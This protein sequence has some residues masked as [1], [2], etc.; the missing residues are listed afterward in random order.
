MTTGRGP[1][2]LI[3]GGLLDTGPGRLVEHSEQGCRLLARVLSRTAQGSDAGRRLDATN[4]LKQ[5]AG[6]RQADAFGLGDG[7]EVVLKLRGQENGIL[8]AVLEGLKFGLL[9]VE[10]VAQLVDLGLGGLTFDRLNDVL[11]LAVEGLT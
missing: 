1:K 6:D 11:G 9:G 10:L 5:A 4:D 2:N 8:Q 3:G 7:G